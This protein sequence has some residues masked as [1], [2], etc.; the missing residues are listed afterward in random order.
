MR[1][2]DCANPAKGGRVALKCALLVI[3]AFPCQY[4]GKPSPQKMVNSSITR[5]VKSVGFEANTG[6]A[7]TQ[8]RFAGYGPNYR[9]LLTLTDVV[10]SSTIPETRKDRHPADP[11]QLSDNSVR[12]SFVDTS[13]EDFTR[14]HLLGTNRR[15]QAE[16]RK[17]LSSYSNYLIGKDPK[18]WRTHVPQFAEVWYPAIYPGIDQV[19]YNHDGQIEYDFIVA[20]RG[21]PGRIQFLIDESGRGVGIR[22]NAEGDL[23]IP[24]VQGNLVLHK[25]LLFQGE[26]C[27]AHQTSG[28]ARS[29][30]GC[31]P[32][33]G[34][35]FRIRRTGR[36]AVKVG[37]QLPHYDHSQSLIIDPSVSFS[38]FLGGSMGDGVDGMTLDADGNIYLI[39]D[40]NSPDFPTTAGAYQKNIAGDVD[41]FVVKLSG[42]GS[43]IIYS[44][45]LGGS[46]AEFPHGIAIDSAKNVYLAGETYSTDFPLV[47]PYQSTTSGGTGFVSKLSPDGSSL[48]YSTYLGG[49]LEG[50]INAIAVD[51]SSG[52]A[53]VV[54]RTGSIDF[55]VVN[56]F[57]PAH[58]ADGGSSEA[59]VTKFGADGTSLVFSTYLGGDSNDFGQGIAI[60]SSGS[61]YV[62]GATASTNFPT[63]PGAYQPGYIA[64][65]GNSSFV[66]KFSASGTSLAYSTY[67]VD[68]YA[69]G[70]AVNAAGNAFVTGQ[71]YDFAFPVTPGAFQTVHGAGGG[72]DAFVTEFDSTGSSLV[73]STFLGGNNGDVGYAIALDSSDDAYV[74]GQ[75]FSP[76]FPLQA[77]TQTV[78]YVGVPTT[79]VSELNSLGSALAF[80]TYWGGGAGG[81]GGSQANAIAVGAPGNIYTSGSTTVPDFPVVN[82]IQSQLLGPGDAFIA[83]FKVS[84]DFTAS[85]SPGSRT[86]SAGQT[87]SYSLTVAP[88]NGYAGNVSLSCSGAPTGSKCTVSPS[89]L[90]LDG[91]HAVP[92]TLTAT[93]TA[94]S[95]N[96]LSL[97]G[98][99]TGLTPTTRVDWTALG[100]VFAVA[101]C[102]GTPMAQKSRVRPLGA[103]VF[104]LVA[105]FMVG[106][107]GGSGGGGGGGGGTPPGNYTI[108]VKTSSGAV[109]HNIS[110]G[111]TVN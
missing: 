99:G 13:K 86:V 1:H 37:F 103:M 100:G 10:L 108:I 50:A 11:Q 89:S 72:Y 93:T 65:P 47:N 69:F 12:K 62:T 105:S 66:T 63:T 48:I 28:R 78:F 73:Y 34:G 44:T 92:A 79:F 42:D 9:I 35:N 58:A 56:A 81:Y 21:N 8:V 27:S 68:C 102:F 61:I 24:A 31:R 38:T 29:G 75:T 14:V 87:A 41:A 52:E 97:G 111:L 30:L 91:T 36:S 84:P 32:L 7:S 94:P 23:V 39:G 26:S 106:C 76:D 104:L 83:N 16:G 110:F 60:D 20:P 109:S 71:A 53:V 96:A 85:G 55:P 54:G 19:Y 59:F 90:T 15:S 33:P 40:T 17:R 70:I 22:V 25:P 107:G 2:Y 74:T 67:L 57:Q 4:V 6:W 46:G 80:S 49:S 18:K 43:H 64:D 5:V 98:K 3:I 77:P 95:G 88:I 45:F 82:A 101:L 51:T